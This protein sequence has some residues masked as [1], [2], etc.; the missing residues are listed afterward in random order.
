MICP[1]G[2]ESNSSNPNPYAFSRY[3]EKGELIYA[4]CFHG[5]IV[6]NKTGKWQDDSQLRDNN[7]SN[8]SR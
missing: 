7:E 4:I 1:C 8:N 3:N 2:R 5:H 6:V